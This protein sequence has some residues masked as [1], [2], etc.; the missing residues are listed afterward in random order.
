MWESL[1]PCT[2]ELLR[3]QTSASQA[4]LEQ[5]NL[6]HSLLLQSSY[7]TKYTCFPLNS[8]FAPNETTKNRK[9]TPPISAFRKNIV[10]RTLGPP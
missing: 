5:P 2:R 10:P 6:E 7:Q 4:L 1:R 9:S 3:F 8:Q